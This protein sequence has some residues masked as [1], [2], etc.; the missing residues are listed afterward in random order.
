MSADAPTPAHTGEHGGESGIRAHN[1]SHVPKYKENGQVV[2]ST[3]INPEDQVWM[4]YLG[5]AEKDDKALTENIKGDTDGILIFTGLFAATVA[6]FIVQTY[7]LLSSNPNDVTV[8][9]LF[10]ISQ[11]LSASVNDTSGVPLF[12]DPSTTFSPSRK[13][14]CFNALWFLSLLLSLCSALTATLMQQ[15]T[16]RYTRT[17]QRRGQPRKRGLLHVYLA[18]GIKRFGLSESVEA[19][20]ALLHASVFLFIAGLII[21]LFDQCQSIAWIVAGGAIGG[22]AIYLV[23]SAFPLCAPDAPYRTPLTPALS[24]I[25]TARALRA[26]RSSFLTA[27]VWLYVAFD[28]LF[29]ILRAMLW[30]CRPRAALATARQY[31]EMFSET[32]RARAPFTVPRSEVPP[33]EDPLQ[34]AMQTQDRMAYLALRQTL[35]KVDENN[36]LEEFLVALTHFLRSDSV[37]SKHD[38]LYPLFTNDG[39]GE[40]MKQLL[41]SCSAY[42]APGSPSANIHA[43]R[44]FILGRVC[45]DLCPYFFQSSTDLDVDYTAYNI[46][47]PRR[48]PA[49]QWEDL[50]DVWSVD[51]SGA[52][53]PRISSIAACVQARLLLQILKQCPQTQRFWL[54]D[55]VHNPKFNHTKNFIQVTYSILLS[56]NH[57]PNPL[58]EYTFLLPSLFDDLA[59]CV[60]SRPPDKGSKMDRL[61]RRTLREIFGSDPSVED[62]TDS[63][64]QLDVASGRWTGLDAALEQQPAVVR[65]LRTVA[66]SI[67]LGEGTSSH[68]AR[69]RA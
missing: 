19:I 59:Q 58:G 34:C 2:G 16:R 30:R 68:Y 35:K 40:R 66:K 50:I 41:L 22:L 32:L 5:E 23:L 51:L 1:R 8:A 18:Q 3:F 12:V 27:I 44:V 29:L 52:A 45:L 26:V 36:E 7:P 6:G 10:R 47:P 61:L 65:A 31:S 13:V 39:L 57:N 55:P 14:V 4:L 11:Q 15:W 17:V 48:P 38:I 43:Q 42:C 25:G 63:G 28:A 49:L 67:S 60:A 37:Q 24:V 64:I 20:V 46:F 54:H 62:P 21:F 33:L 9:L 53:D 56:T 69:P